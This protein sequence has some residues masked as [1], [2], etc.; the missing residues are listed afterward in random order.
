MRPTPRRR[1]RASRATQLPL[2]CCCGVTAASRGPFAGRPGPRHSGQAGR[3]TCLPEH[4]HITRASPA[5]ACACAHAGLRLRPHSRCM[6]ASAPAPRIELSQQPSVGGGGGG[7]AWA[8]A[9][10]WG[11]QPP[12][13][14]KC[15]ARRPPPSRRPAPGRPPQPPLQSYRIHAPAACERATCCGRPAARRLR[16]CLALPPGQ[17]RYPSCMPGRPGRRRRC[18]RP[19]RCRAARP[20]RPPYRRPCSRPR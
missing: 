5:C 17:T 11:L 20:G 9:S 16:R 15:R 7:R 8:W 2:S 14:C 3:G 4:H 12:S 6:P 19:R 10:S 18:C 13:A 1:S